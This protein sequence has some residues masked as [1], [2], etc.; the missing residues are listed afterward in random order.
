ME[1]GPRKATD[2][3]LDMESKIDI[4]INLVRTQDLNIKI[5]T[6]KLNVLNEK[7]DKPI[8]APQSI[9]I[10]AV[11]T[12]PIAVENKQVQ[13]SPEN[14]ISMEKEPKGF[15][16]TSRPETYAGD[17]SYLKPPAKNQ[18]NTNSAKYPMQMPKHFEPEVIVPQQALKPIEINTNNSVKET[19]K[20]SGAN[21]ISVI[22]RIVDKNGKSVFLADVEILTL[23]DKQTVTK[24]RTNGAGKWM[25][26]LPMG[27]YKVF[28][29]KKEA[30]NKDK[31]E[32]IQEIKVDGTKSQVELPT[33]IIKT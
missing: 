14:A 26:S 10:E 9:R 21:N 11:D 15:R 27:E 30:V 2:V 16:R 20:M 25:A 13:V 4:L 7:L 1:N 28:I 24:T 33:A 22:Q 31:M 6:N 8:S 3:I 5:L 12:T 18:E 29:R 32:V 23:E 17:N 19:Q